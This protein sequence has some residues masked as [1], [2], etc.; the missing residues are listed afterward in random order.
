[1]ATISLP[2]T[3]LGNLPEPRSI[4][5]PASPLEM[6]GQMMGIKNAQQEQTLRQQLAPLQ[7]EQAQEGVQSSQLDVE[8]KQ[9]AANDQKAM[10]AVMQQWGKTP[11]SAAAQPSVTTTTGAITNPQTEETLSAGT[12][13][14][15]KGPSEAG[16]QGK[17][18]STLPS[19]DDLVPLA[20][21]NGA[22]WQTVQG[23][24]AHVLEMKAKA[25]TIAKD[26]AQTGTA[27]A[28]SIRTNNGIIS[29]AMMGVMNLP[30]AQLPQGILSAAN[31][32][33]QKGIF[34]PQHV[35]Q[36]Q[37]LAQLSQSDPNQARQQLNIQNMSLG[38]FSKELEAQQK[39]VEITKGQL[40]NQVEQQQLNYGGNQM[41][42]DSKYRFIEQRKAEG[43][44]PSADEQ[45]FVKAYEKQK[46][47]VPVATSQ[48]RIEGLGAMR[49]YPVFDNQTKAT[50]MMNANDLNAANRQ[51]PGRFTAPGY[52]PEALGQRG[53]T[54]YFTKGKGSQQLTAYNTAL[55]HLDTLDSLAGDLNNSNIQVF[56]KAAQTWKEQTGN[57]APSNFAAAKNAMSGEVAAALKAS[58]ATDQE[59]A[60]VGQTFNRAQGPAQLK[61]AIG[62]YRTLLQSKAQQLHGQ[63]EQGMQ[64]RPNFGE[65]GQPG[66]GNDQTQTQGNS[67]FATFGGSAH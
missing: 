65:S 38:A 16:A 21:K 54:E 48:V 41:M 8:A 29:D 3:H 12:P 22:S 45:A 14:T 20:I 53:T 42:A 18:A 44:A 27:K 50:I 43:I 10:S 6:Y 2:L 39:Q 26:D 40:G 67:P 25:S 1:M 4:A 30:D 60:S 36:A 34:D 59:I 57:P 11:G 55:K 62:T 47:L 52:T 5:P 49:E 28:D 46:L 58:G 7:V 17:P 31:E 35:Q 37:Q 24:Q 32:L 61:G 66:S 23:V 33:S 63:Y 64:G 9:R 13:L 19:Y 15:V 51:Q 56:N